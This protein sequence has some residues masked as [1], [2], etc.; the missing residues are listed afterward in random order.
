W[1]L[2]EGNEDEQHWKGN[3][4]LL[5][6]GPYT[7]RKLSE[8]QRCE[9]ELTSPADPLTGIQ[10][11]RT[12][13]LDADSP[14]IRFHAVMKNI[15]GHSLEWSMQSVSQYATSAPSNPGV[16]NRNFWT[17][18]PANP[19]SS[20]LNRYHV[21]FGPAENRAV[22]VRDDGLFTVHYVSMAAEL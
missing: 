15:S 8:G 17:F 3:S 5:D 4:D 19:A 7:F 20:Y 11:S 10:F 6:D 9:I 16:M 14:R 12:I 18:T 13:R 22:E 1:L 21:R 2:P